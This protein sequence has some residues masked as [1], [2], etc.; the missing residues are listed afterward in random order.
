MAVSFKLSELRLLESQAL[1]E[2]FLAEKIFLGF[3]EDHTRALPRSGEVSGTSFRDRFSKQGDTGM[4]LSHPSDNMLSPRAKVVGN[5]PSRPLSATLLVYKEDAR[6]RVLCPIAEKIP[7]KQLRSG[8]RRRESFSFW[9][10]WQ[11]ASD[12]MDGSAG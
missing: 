9:R 11:K 3:Q 2:A 5:F 6:G 4:N 7:P 10:I 1:R 8:E 12:H